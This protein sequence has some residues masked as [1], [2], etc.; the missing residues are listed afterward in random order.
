[1]SASEGRHYTITEPPLGTFHIWCA[2]VRDEIP[3]WGEDNRGNP[4][5]WFGRKQGGEIEVCG[6]KTMR[7]AKVHFGITI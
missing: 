3:S 7:E 2:R 4:C 6:V 1:M 5:R